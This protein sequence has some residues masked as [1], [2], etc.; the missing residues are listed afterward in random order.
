MT[1]GRPTD[2]HHD[3]DNLDAD[4]IA[5]RWERALQESEDAQPAEVPEGYDPDG[6][7]E[8]D[9]S[10]WLS[11]T[12]DR[13]AEIDAILADAGVTP[14]AAEQMQ[15]ELD[16][17]EAGR[18]Y[19]AHWD[20]FCA[21][22]MPPPELTPEFKFT[23]I[24]LRHPDRLNAASELLDRMVAAG[25]GN[26][27][28]FRTARIIWTYQDVLLMANAMADA[29]LDDFGVVPGSR[30]LLRGYNTPYLFIAFLALLKLGAV[31]VPT[32]P[33][34]RGPALARIAS[35]T[36]AS[37]ILCEDRLADELYQT[38]QQSSLGCELIQ[39]SGTQQ[40]F[41]AQLQATHPDSQPANN[42]PWPRLEDHIRTRNGQFDNFDTA[43]EDVC[44]IAL[45]GGTSGNVKGAMHHHRDLLIAADGLLRTTLMASPQ[46][47]F[48]CNMP[49][50]AVSG[51][52]SL[53]L[54]PMR[55]GASSILLQQTEAKTLL[56]SIDRLGA[57]IV[58]CTP[59][60]LRHMLDI[61][62]QYNITSLQT[63]ICNGEPL[64]AALANRWMNLTGCRLVEGINTT[65]MLA[66]FIAS[67]LD[68]F[69]PGSTGQPLDG[70][71][72][73]VVDES[74]RDMPPNMRGRLVVKGP[75]GYR[76]I[77]TENQAHYVQDG[78]NVTGDF[79]SIDKEG[80]FWFRGRADD[81]IDNG[82]YEVFS[83]KVEAIL[84]DH[85][86][87]M[88]IGVVAA[89]D[90]ALGTLV[91]GYVV[92]GPKAPPPDVFARE[93]TLY[94]RERMDVY[95]APIRWEFVTMLPRSDNGTL[96]RYRLRE[97]AKRQYQKEQATQGV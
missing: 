75:I 67:P 20:S 11:E 15:R 90:K 93:L 64:S 66:M 24:W 47:I 78:W 36:E 81:I 76:F 8:P 60:N 69:L 2:H 71:M 18:R 52:L 73:R 87:I 61:H 44:L 33:S 88:D 68:D 25:H 38:D 35:M 6:A 86:D 46:D 39:F 83:P 27:P 85:P 82:G 5:A 48:S 72:C 43:A 3:D 91:K 23:R 53:L 56:Q 51:L 95:E 4:I 10:V 37:C 79:Y 80:F 89:P 28:C 26:S 29:L 31:A 34:M 84:A 17:L 32:T 1:Q 40:L 30:V 9:V 92:P 57:T 94:A 13:Q 77:G 45:T 16:A 7:W 74:M 65:G 96:L 21:D 14:E 97:H 58:L 55:V 59:T 54:L 42:I 62:Q 41:L 19:T 63:V 22:H 49:L 12:Q 50:G 70:F